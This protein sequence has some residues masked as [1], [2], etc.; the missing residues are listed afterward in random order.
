M[1]SENF[2]LKIL[3]CLMNGDM[4]IL[5]YRERETKQEQH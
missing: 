2:I 5:I 1:N 4:D 3:F